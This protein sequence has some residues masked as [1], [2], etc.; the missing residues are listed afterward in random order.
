MKDKNQ[1]LGVLFERTSRDK[2]RYLIYTLCSCKNLQQKC[3][4]KGFQNKNLQLT[5]IVGRV[6]K[7]TG[8]SIK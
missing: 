4:N 2:M 7:A 3:E 6:S 8:S 1:Q 5:F